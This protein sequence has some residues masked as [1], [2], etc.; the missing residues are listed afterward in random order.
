MSTNPKNAKARFWIWISFACLLGAVVGFA[1]CIVTMI[2]L[3]AMI[4]Y[5][6]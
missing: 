3:Q 5:A 4:S 2:V 1:A 6:Q